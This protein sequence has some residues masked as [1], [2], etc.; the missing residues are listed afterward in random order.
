MDR[1]SK[2]TGQNRFGEETG[3]VSSSRNIC[4]ILRRGA[5]VD[6]R[7]KIIEL[8]GH[9]GSS[10]VYKVEQVFLRR[11]FALKVF[12]PDDD[13]TSPSIHRFHQEAQLTSR[14]EHQNI[15]RT[16]DCG[17]LNECQ[18]FLVME[19]I[20]GPT[21][22]QLLKREGSLSLEVTVKLLAPIC[23]ALSYA[24]EHGL[25][26]RDIKPSNIIIETHT[27]GTMI[28]KLVDF[29]I[30]Q[31]IEQSG[32]RLTK[33]G[34]IFGTPLYMSPEQC[35]GSRVDHRA[36][37][38]SMG[39]VL[40]EALTGAPPFIGANLLETTTHH[41]HTVPMSLTDGAMGKKFPSGVER[42]VLRALEKN[43]R[44][45]YQSCE[46]L[47][48]DLLSAQ[49]DS[50]KTD[51]PPQAKCT[52]EVV[53]E[54]SSIEESK[55]SKKKAISIAVLA[56]ISTLTLVLVGPSSFHSKVTDSVTTSVEAEKTS[57]LPSKEGVFY[58]IVDGM[59]VPLDSKQD[60][61]RSKPGE[62]VRRYIFPTQSIGKLTVTDQN[63]QSAV[64]IEAAGFVSLRNGDHLS[65]SPI[66]NLI[67]KH[68]EALDHF[69]SDDLT[70]IV[71]KVRPELSM[72][73]SGCDMDKVLKHAAHYKALKRVNLSFTDVTA[74]GLRNFFIDDKPNLEVLSISRTSINPAELAKLNCIRKVVQLDAEGLGKMTPVFSSL[75]NSNR[76]KVLKVNEDQVDDSDLNSIAK[77]KNLEDLSI[78][79]NPAI[80]KQG[81]T[82]LM[83]LK[84]LRSLDLHGTHISK[85]SLELLARLPITWIELPSEFWSPMDA[86]DLYKAMKAKCDVSFA[87]K[88]G[89]GRIRVVS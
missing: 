87:A 30:A 54:K 73:D 8:L 31:F 10:S 51:V 71:F 81:L 43:V 55:P 37:I 56:A 60:Y 29:G 48:R 24:H 49:I 19:L 45:R 79:A 76:L 21:L 27:D 9:G 68:P 44:D 39:C 42:A 74:A 38:Y 4:S 88:S 18:P 40:Y 32:L 70:E 23:F 82:A 25:V 34:E 15:C 64:Q 13:Q 5:I 41:L 72:L 35:R 28:P 66:M 84:K 16:I 17:V 77:L 57:P 78:A 75:Q 36:D 65:F 26:H 22:H 89:A 83:Q 14:L 86:H 50:R 53:R 1:I 61:C 59:Q 47:G 80:T 62:L 85:D 33:T 3:P 52:L 67:S 46:D 7:Y 20:E 12:E 11:Q 63:F 69:Q 6:G 2:S 58:S